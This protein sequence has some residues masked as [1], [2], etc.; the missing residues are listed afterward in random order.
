MDKNKYDRIVKNI[1]K[2]KRYIIK[3][4]LLYK[5]KKLNSN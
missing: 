4:G 5:I 1:E 2:K 3:E